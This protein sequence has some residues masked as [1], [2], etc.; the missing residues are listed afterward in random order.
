MAKFIEKI[1]E[2]RSSKNIPLELE[3]FRICLDDLKAMSPCEWYDFLLNKYFLWKYTNGKIRSYLTKQFES[4]YFNNKT[5]L[6][7]IKKEIL[8]IDPLEIRE[9]IA[10]VLKIKG[11]GVGGATGLLSLIFPKYFGTLDQFLVIALQNISSS[12]QNINPNNLNLDDA[13]RL[14]KILRKISS[15]LNNTIIINCFRVIRMNKMGEY[16]IE[17]FASNQQKFESSL[18]KL[19]GWLLNQ[20][21]QVPSKKTLL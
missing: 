8:V 14:T 2:L 4:A 11:I 15:S 10:T 16:C 13:V 6:D 5:S 18:L 9:S 20:K 1:L 21:G 3:L 12:L 17:I 19:L 7:K